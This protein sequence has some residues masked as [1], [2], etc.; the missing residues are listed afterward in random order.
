MNTPFLVAIAATAVR[1]STIYSPR[2]E[3]LSPA[4]I[5][6]FAPSSSLVVCARSSALSSL[7]PRFLET[8][9]PLFHV[10]D[11]DVMG[12]IHELLRDVQY[13]VPSLHLTLAEPCETANASACGCDIVIDVSHALPS[14]VL[15]IAWQTVV[16]GVVSRA[17]IVFSL[18]ACWYTHSAVCAFAR[19]VNLN[20]LMPLGVV[21]VTAISVGPTIVWMAWILRQ[22]AQWKDVLRRTPSLLIV[23]VLFLLTTGPYLGWAVYQPCIRCHD[24]RATLAHEL[25][26]ALS[27]GHPDENPTWTAGECQNKRWSPNRPTVPEAPIDVV[28]GGVAPLMTSVARHMSHTCLTASDQR[29]LDELHTQPGDV[30]STPPVCDERWNPLTAYR[31][32]V[33]MLMLLGGS[34]LVV[35]GAR[36]ADLWVQKKVVSP[37]D[38]RVMTYL[39]EAL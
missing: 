27:L 22:K 29:G 14:S 4:Q 24:F 35:T 11:R 18:D 31:T 20:P 17:D 10:N 12:E 34:A 30:C 16:A 25:G 7:V 33:L 38:A 19:E 36:T 9:G 23:G 21:M 28:E 15:A 5:P 13:N 39:T 37:P 32:S 26:H 8:R 6:V 3:G 2:N 1:F